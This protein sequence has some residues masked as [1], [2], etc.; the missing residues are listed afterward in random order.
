MRLLQQKSCRWWAHV[1]WTSDA[2]NWMHA[3]R[4]KVPFW[5]LACFNNSDVWLLPLLTLLWLPST[6]NKPRQAFIVNNWIP[7]L[8][9]PFTPPPHPS[10]YRH[11]LFIIYFVF[12]WSSISKADYVII[13]I[14]CWVRGLQE[15]HWS[16]SSFNQASGELSGMWL[17]CIQ[18]THSQYLRAETTAW[19][20]M[21]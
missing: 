9:P 2:A 21:I 12:V 13:W 3:L 4:L 11:K 10:G 16:L 19:V 14:K 20:F 1:C 8:I 18:Q 6:I 7:P 15:V 5:F 17:E